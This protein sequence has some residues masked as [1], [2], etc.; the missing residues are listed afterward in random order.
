MIVK[1]WEQ[2]IKELLGLLTLVVNTVYPS[3]CLYDGGNITKLN[4]LFTSAAL[5][6]RPLSL[7]YSSKS[8]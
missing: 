1:K 4:L 5:C 6:L 3:S 7:S 2:G 8:R